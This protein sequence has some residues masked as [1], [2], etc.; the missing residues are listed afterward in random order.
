MILLQRE[1]GWGTQLVVRPS[2]G[3]LVV[4]LPSWVA[5][6]GKFVGLL[7]CTEPRC[8]RRYEDV[9]LEGWGA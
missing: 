5:P 7:E 3:H 8:E 1:Q 9:V 4:I 6:D 2:C